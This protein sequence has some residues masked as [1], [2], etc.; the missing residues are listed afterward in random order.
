MSLD[1]SGKAQKTP[2]QRPGRPLV[3]IHEYDML[4]SALGVA[5]EDARNFH[6]LLSSDAAQ[7]AC[8]EG[9]LCARHSPRC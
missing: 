6:S 1:H 3:A 8:I 9:L 4:L 2:F 5:R 7:C